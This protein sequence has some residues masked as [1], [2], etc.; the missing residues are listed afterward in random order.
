MR[1]LILHSERAGRRR[2]SKA[3]LVGA[4]E[5]AGHDVSYRSTHKPRWKRQLAKPDIVV[6]AGGD[7]TVAKVAIALAKHGHTAP[8]AVIPA[9]KA[10]NIAR[11]LGATGSVSQLARAIERPPNARLAIGLI[12]SPWGKVRFVESVGIG[13]LATLLRT[14]VPTLRGAVRVL[15]TAFRREPLRALRIRA[16]GRDRSGRYVVVHAMNID[17]VGPRLVYAPGADPGDRTLDLVLLEESARAV[18]NRYLDRLAAGKRARCPVVPIRVR[19]IEI[20]P[21]RARD[22]GHVD[23][24]LWPKERRPKRGTVRIE[25][26]TTIRV[27]VARR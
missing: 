23:D 15:R 12:R 20:G 10:N 3:T 4:F 7:G 22:S 13:P 9:G 19:S 17:A 6:V 11:S 14:D 25:V 24:K 2:L 18:F 27:L 1:V 8:L 5:R 21:W 26:E 16:D